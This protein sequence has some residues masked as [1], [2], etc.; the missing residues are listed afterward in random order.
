MSGENYF[1]SSTGKSLVS[2]K[3]P[4]TIGWCNNNSVNDE[5]FRY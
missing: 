5:T 2:S 3:K 1:T 4:I